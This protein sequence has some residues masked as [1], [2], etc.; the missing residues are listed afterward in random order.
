[1]VICKTIERLGGIC[2]IQYP[3]FGQILPFALNGSV[4]LPVFHLEHFACSLSKSTFTK[5]AHNRVRPA[6]KVS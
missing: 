4:S 1:M 2:V 3:R 5:N 6:R